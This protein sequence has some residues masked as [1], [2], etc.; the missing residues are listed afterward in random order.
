MPDYGVTVVMSDRP[1]G[2]RDLE[3]MREGAGVPAEAF[4]EMQCSCGTRAFWIVY[5][6]GVLRTECR[7]C[8]RQ[9]AFAIAP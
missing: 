3:R 4:A 9:M 7:E 2:A 5:R 1:V 6:G 8:C